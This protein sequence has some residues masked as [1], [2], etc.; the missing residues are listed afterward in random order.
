[1][2]TNS[3]QAWV[4]DQLLKSIPGDRVESVVEWLEQHFTVVGSARSPRFDRET[5]PWLNEPIEMAGGSKARKVTLIK[6][7]QT[8]GSTSGEGVLLHWLATW[9]GGDICS[10]FPN[11]EVAEERWK[12]HSEKKIRAC[13]AVMDRV[14]EDRFKFSNGMVVF[15]HCNLVQQGV[16]ADRSVASDSFR[17]L[18]LEEC[19][20]KEGGWA[21]GRLDQCYGRQTAYWNA[22]AFIISCAGF[23]NTDLHKAFLSGSQ[24]HWEVKCPGCG[25]YHRMRAKWDENEPELGGLRYDATGCRLPNR[26]YNYQK[27]ASTIRYQF[28]CGHTI[29]DDVE[30]RRALSKTGRYSAGDNPG[31]P[32]NE[33]SYTYESVSCDFIPWLDLIKRK[34]GALLAIDLSHDFKPYFDYL[35]ECEVRFVDISKDRPVIQRQEIIVNKSLKKNRDGLPNKAFRFASGD[36]QKGRVSMGEGVHWWLLIQDFAENGDSQIVWEGKCLTD[37]ELVGVLREHQVNPLC[38]VLDASW[39]AVNV[40][41]FALKHGF[42]CLKVEPRDFFVHEDGSRRIW[43][44]PQ[45]LCDVAGAPPSQENVDLEP[46]FFHVGKFSAMERLMFLRQCKLVQF[47]IPGDV[48]KDFHTHFNSWDQEIIRRK[49]GQVEVKWRQLSDDDHLFQCAAYNLVQADMVDLV[50]LGRALLLMEQQKEEQTVT[51]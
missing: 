3:G 13:K 31:A 50:G 34:H 40:Y 24:Q 19:W 6:P 11:Q 46:D 43:S 41:A 42:H 32:A 5:A 23:V 20:D 45:M 22:V 51:A 14:P 49:D 21:D 38:V 10:Y 27:L 17:G 30:L 8:G 48:S 33:K 37:G 18:L 7:I 1:M 12:K 25:L 47:V 44:E 9:Q 2:F 4:I 26:Q 28:P 35:R 16:R 36:R 29:P 15:P 39:D